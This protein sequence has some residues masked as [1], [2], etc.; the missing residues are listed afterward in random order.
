LF[1]SVF[2]LIVFLCG[3]VAAIGCPLHRTGA[4]PSSSIWNVAYA[5]GAHI[6]S[7]AQQLSPDTPSSPGDRVRLVADQK[8]GVLRVVIDGKPVAWLDASGFHV[9]QDIEYGGSITDTGSA[10]LE[11]RAG[12]PGAH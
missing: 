7:A 5:D 4:T 6:P 8:T 12:A 2:V 9:V 11:K 1:R 3:F 10:D